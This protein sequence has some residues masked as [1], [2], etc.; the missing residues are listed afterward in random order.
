MKILVISE[1]KGQTNGVNTTYTNIAP[2]LQGKGHE[3][4]VLGSSDFKGAKPL[5]FY[6]DIHIIP[7]LPYRQVKQKIEDLQPDHIHIATEGTLGWAAQMYCRRHGKEFSTCFHTNFHI[8][9]E[10]Y[11]PVLKTAAR[12]ATIAY[13]RAFHKNS[14][15]L[16]VAT[17]GL[18]RELKEF[19]F[20][21]PMRPFSRGVDTDLFK[22]GLKTLFQ[23][24]AKPVC[25][26][27][28]RIAPEKGIDIFLNADL[29][30]TKIVVG[31]GPA[32]EGLKR[33]HANDNDIV[34]AGRRVGADLAAH[35][36]SADV[37][38]MPSDTETFGIVTIEAL[39]S[40][41]HVIAVPSTANDSILSTPLLG[42]TS[43]D[44]RAAFERLDPDSPD[45]RQ[46]RHQHVLDHYT[47][48][49]AAGQFE[50]NIL[51]LGKT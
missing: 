49:N 30:G 8:Y 41:L 48:P 29:P 23:D 3:I 5:P 22:P 34:F 46:A 2:E 26:Y 35:F 12:K 14:S 33:K 44:L 18:E 28:G 7:W 11:V 13:L 25:L 4:T 47:W 42:S 9:A 31:G 36:R 19:G 15:C 24:A 39:A 32:L 51:S 1:A 6:P 38:C 43:L 50:G 37:F 20:T 21:A 45:A 10:R 40:G 27:V 16:M 17:E